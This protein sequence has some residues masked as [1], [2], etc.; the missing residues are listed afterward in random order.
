MSV[1][2]ADETA[3]RLD[4]FRARAL[5][6]AERAVAAEAGSAGLTA[7]RGRTPL[8]WRIRASRRA[9]PL[10]MRALLVGRRSMTRRLSGALSALLGR[11]R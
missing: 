9:R 3:Q 2:G 11:M 6:A 4:G 7:L 5:R 10:L 1:R 8:E